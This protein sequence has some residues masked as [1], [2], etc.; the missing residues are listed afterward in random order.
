MLLTKFNLKNIS[1][2][3]VSVPAE[4][5]F[6][7]P[8]KVLQFGTGVLLRGLPD[9]FIDKANRK[10][11]FNGR[12]VVVKS[13]EGG[14]AAA[15]DKQDGLYTLCMRG[16]ANGKPVEEN[17]ISASI[18]RV[19]SAAKE[20]DAVLQ[21]AHNPELTIIISNTTEV[22]IELV[23][24]D[25][26]KHPPVSYPG[27]LLAFLHER[28]K[29]FNGSAKAGLVIVPTE[30]ISDNGKK[31]EAIVL[32]QA[33]LNGLEDK[34]IE[35]LEQSNHFCNSLVDRIVP[36]K[37]DATKKAALEA[38][39]GYHDDLI[40]MSEVYSLWAIEGDD[41]V[42]EVLSF[43]GADEGIVITDD[44]TLFKELKLRLLNGTHTL[45]CGVAFLAGLT[46]VKEAMNNP[47]LSGF[48]KELMLKEI[49]VAIPYPVP[50]KDAEAFALKVIDRYSNPSIEHQWISI[51][52]NYTAKLKMRVVQ[53]LQRYNEL[54]NT[55]PESMA[56]GFAAWLLF[57]KAVKKEN[58]V[59]YGELAGQPYPIK[60]EMA[61]YFFNNWQNLSPQ[62]LV[63]TVL[64]DASLWDADLTLIPGFAE[65]VTEKLLEIM[66]RGM[67]AML[68]QE[69]IKIE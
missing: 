14:D 9:Y 63:K 31:L 11:I 13:T 49:A 48:I 51:T 39:L 23:N 12:I 22:G 59:Y 60:D 61:D 65:T 64:S 57:M 52:L 35:W 24:D 19:L 2:T 6:D 53:V 62:S 66:Q 8:E 5:L 3:N 20:W 43:A 46:T 32:E 33:H 10:G 15:F 41:H 38:T 47:V 68:Q 25:I 34:F 58:N 69:N 7:L 16:L 1:N 30:L 54:Y 45:S 50:E 55:F 17:V 42:K 28:Y 18:N 26:R 37:P 40:T 36:G 56:T 4:N 67:L 27:K 44:I 29:A 21:C